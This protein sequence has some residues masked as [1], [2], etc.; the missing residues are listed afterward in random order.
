MG[1]MV[2]EVLAKERRPT[3]CVSLLSKLVLGAVDFCR[4]S[5]GGIIECAQ[6]GLELRQR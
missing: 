1:V 5:G 6:S 2:M 4:M 3:V